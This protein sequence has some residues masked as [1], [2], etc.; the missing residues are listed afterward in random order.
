MHACCRTVLSAIKLAYLDHLRIVAV[1]VAQGMPFKVSVSI[2]GGECMDDVWAVIMDA[3]TFVGLFEF[4][5]R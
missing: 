1:A 5:W 2:V 4:A 3:A